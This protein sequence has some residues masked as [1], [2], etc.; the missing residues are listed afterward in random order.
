VTGDSA[1]PPQRRALVT[2]AGR[3]I[4]RA[5]ALALADAGV[6]VL[7]VSRTQS[8]LESLAREAPIEV[9]PTS[10]GDPAGCA[11]VAEYAVERLGGVDILVHSAGVDTHRER[12]IWLQDAAVWQD[13][14]AVN[15]H[16][17]F[18]LARLLTG[19][20]VQRGWGRIVM[21]SST[22]GE[23]GGPSSSAYCAAKHAVVGMVRAIAQDVAPHGVTCNAV[24]P[25]WVRGTGM[26]D[27]TAELEAARAGISVEEVWVRLEAGTAAGRVSRPEEVA[28]A[29]AYLASEGAAAINGEALRIALGEVW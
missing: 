10:L 2:G 23:W 25:G 29:I 21:V 28:S 20:M 26:S 1:E 8:E 14:M 13:T 7:G 18:E 5:A 27:R 12:P 4:G 19:A 3:G 15:A 6:R 24:L 17:A 22:A 16:A 9:H 11:T